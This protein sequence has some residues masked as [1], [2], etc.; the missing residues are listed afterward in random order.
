ME[1]TYV[2]NVQSIGDDEVEAL[3]VPT[4]N[5]SRHDGNDMISDGHNDDGRTPGD[6]A[7]PATVRRVVAAGVTGRRNRGGGDTLDSGGSDGQTP[8]N[9]HSTLNPP[10]NVDD[11]TETPTVVCADC[12]YTFTPT[13]VKPL[14]LPGMPIANK[15]G[16]YLPVDTDDSTDNG[17]GVGPYG[18]GLEDPPKFCPRCGAAV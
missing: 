18:D 11:S 10:N 13:P 6:P 8:G 16:R 2:E 12:G 1:S 14:L 3:E 5:F 9:P 17:E 7:R 4:Y 15:K